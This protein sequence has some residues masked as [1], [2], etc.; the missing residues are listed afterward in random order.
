MTRALRGAREIKK[1]NQDDR[2][3]ARTGPTLYQYTAV[4]GRG[5]RAEGQLRPPGSAA[6]LR[7]DCVPAVPQDHEARSGGPEVGGPRPVC[8]VEW[9][10]IDAAVW[11]AA[12]LGLQP[13]AG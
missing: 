10:R 12:S 7:A 2:R 4:S 3:A 13:A 1:R 5:R 8:A 9:A 11:V 6:G